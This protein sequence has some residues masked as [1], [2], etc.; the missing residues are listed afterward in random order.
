MITRLLSSVSVL[1]G[2]GL[3]CIED[4]GDD[5]DDACFADCLSITSEPLAFFLSLDDDEGEEESCRTKLLVFSLE[6][7]RTGPPPA[8]PHPHPP[9]TD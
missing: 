5:D 7:T 2:P 8:P 6:K 3:V 9:S 1:S 4:V